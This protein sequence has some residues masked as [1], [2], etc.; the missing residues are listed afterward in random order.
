MSDNI[1]RW[2]L[3]VLVVEDEAVN[4]KILMT[5]LCRFVDEVREAHDGFE[6]LEVLKDFEPDAMITDL[7]MPRLDGLSL[8]REVR[9]Q[10]KDFPILVLSA[11]NEQGILDRA[12]S[13]GATRFL[14]KPVRI[15]LVQEA[16][17]EIAADR[18][19]A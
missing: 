8:I 15:A 10:N 13:L 12:D 7:S 3:K 18:G 2:P 9:L 19:R 14:F 6:A 1:K 17:A 5:I 4:R 16:L 11:H